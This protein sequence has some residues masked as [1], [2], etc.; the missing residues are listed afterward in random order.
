MM[1]V[2]EEVTDK[3]L[4]DCINQVLKYEKLLKIKEK[5]V[6]EKDAVRRSDYVT[7]AQIAME[8]IKLRKML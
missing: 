3:E 1:S 7:A 6:E 2:N 8:I 5:Q 4:T